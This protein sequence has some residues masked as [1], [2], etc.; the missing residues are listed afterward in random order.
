MLRFGFLFVEPIVRRGDVNIFLIFLPL[1][2]DLFNNLLL[3][4]NDSENES[5]ILILFKAFSL[6]PLPVGAQQKSR[7]FGA[8][9]IRRPFNRR[10]L[11]PLPLTNYLNLK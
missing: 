11:Y 3:N 8:L 9:L 1:F 5:I 4:A 6:K 10:I 7:F 2:F